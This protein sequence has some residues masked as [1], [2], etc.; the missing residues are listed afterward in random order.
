MVNKIKNTRG[1]HQVIAVIL[2]TTIASR[3]FTQDSSYT[4]SPVVS[5]WKEYAR[6]VLH[7]PEKKMIELRT[8][9]PGLRYD[10]RYAGNNNF[11]QRQMYP[12]G[13]HSTFL[14]APVA[15]ALSRVDA[16][17]KEKGLGLK[18]FDAYRPYSV[19]VAFWELVHDERYVANPSRGSGHNRG[20]AVDLTLVDRQTGAELP[21]GTGFDNFT[22]TAHA[23]FTA[24]PDNVLNNRKL[25]TS[26]MEKY[27]FRVL[28]TE[29]W[30]FYFPGNDRFEV[31]DISFRKLQKLQR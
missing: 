7:D 9:I 25:L 24:L 10:L 23:D 29:W 26:T 28:Q 30:H 27:G 11:M 3:G 6:Q 14:R 31:L 4:R 1:I 18:I 20:L 19:T 16:E 15:E 12:A 13:T 21:M 22:D 17:L 5:S 8:L 2:F